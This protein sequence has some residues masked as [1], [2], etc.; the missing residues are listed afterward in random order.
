MDTGQIG[1][2]GLNEGKNDMFQ[3]EWYVEHPLS[4]KTSSRW[5][6]LYFNRKARASI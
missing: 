3:R 1:P 5:C 4:L 2:I 6:F